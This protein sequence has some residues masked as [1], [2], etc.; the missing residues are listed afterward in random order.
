M[1]FARILNV[2]LVPLGVILAGLF[3]ALRRRRSIR[4]G[5]GKGGRETDAV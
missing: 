1:D 4:L 3:I 2:V 5:P